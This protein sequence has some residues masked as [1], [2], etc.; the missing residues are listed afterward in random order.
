LRT[1]A[2]F[3]TCWPISWRWDD[4]RGPRFG[5][6]LC[7]G[8]SSTVGA[9]HVHGH[10]LEHASATTACET[11]VALRLC[12]R[13]PTGHNTRAASLGSHWRAP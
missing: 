10:A 9:C 7:R 2:C 13:S 1:S 12:C 6:L 3:Q 11:R 4:E 5:I 8:L